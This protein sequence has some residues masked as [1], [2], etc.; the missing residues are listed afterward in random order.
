MVTIKSEREIA[1]MKQAG[2]ILGNTLKVLEENVKPGI[3]TAEL[4]KI[5][6]LIEKFT[7]FKIDMLSEEINSHFKFARFKLFE[8]QINGGIAE[9]CETTYKG[10]DYS[11]LNNASRINIGLDIVNTLCKINDRYCPVIV[12]NAESVTNIL[13]TTSQMVCLVVSA[14]DDMLRVEKN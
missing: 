12:D 11:Y 6:Y 13:P 7:K 3:T 1:L 2:Q 10:V 14:E 4:D 9:C 8:E 5:A